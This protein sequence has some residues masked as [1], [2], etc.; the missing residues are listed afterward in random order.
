MASWRN[1]RPSVA[2]FRPPG[3][4]E[5]LDDGTEDVPFCQQCRDAG[6]KLMRMQVTG[7]VKSLKYLTCD[8]IYEDLDGIDQESSRRSCVLAMRR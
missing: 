7:W 3:Y 4:R 1:C 8:A 6:G 2:L 5:A